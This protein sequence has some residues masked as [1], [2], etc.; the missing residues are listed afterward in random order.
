MYV[1]QRNPRAVGGSRLC[2]YE[3][4]DLSPGSE[5]TDT[6]GHVVIFAADTGLRKLPAVLDPR[7]VMFFDGFRYA[8]EM[9]ALSYQ[10]LEAA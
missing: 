1:A 3:T 5:S 2:G 7:Q 8:I 4:V 9:A 6:A 10:R